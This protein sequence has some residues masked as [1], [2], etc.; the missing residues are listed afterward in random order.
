MADLPE[1]KW[2]LLARPTL[3]TIRHV[4]RGP[5]DLCVKYVKLAEVFLGRLRNEMALNGVEIATRAVRLPDGTK[6][7]VLRDPSSDILYI[8][9]TETV[10]APYLEFP[11]FDFSFIPKEHY[12]SPVGDDGRAY[13]LG[14]ETLPLSEDNPN[15]KRPMW[16]FHYTGHPYWKGLPD[17]AEVYQSNKSILWGNQFHFDARGRTMVSW[18]HS[19]GGDLPIPIIRPGDYIATRGDSVFTLDLDGYL[20][21]VDLRDGPPVYTPIH[22][23]IRRQVL[24]P[25]GT[26][27]FT[28]PEFRFGHFTADYRFGELPAQLYR[29]NKKW[30]QYEDMIGLI[31]NVPYVAGYTQCKV[32]LEGE[33]TPTRVSDFIVFPID[34]FHSETAPITYMV[35]FSGQLDGYPSATFELGSIMAAALG[36]ENAFVDQEV[37]YPWRFNSTGTEAMWMASVGDRVVGESVRNVRLVWFVFSIDPRTTT[38]GVVEYEVLGYNVAATSSTVA[39]VHDPVGPSSGTEF[40]Y[41]ETQVPGDCAGD[42]WTLVDFNNVEWWFNRYTGT[43]GTTVDERTIADTST[44]VP[45]AYAYSAEDERIV[46]RMTEAYVDHEEWAVTVEDGIFERYEKTTQPTGS[47]FDQY[48]YKDISYEPGREWVEC[49]PIEQPGRLFCLGTSVLIRHSPGYRDVR[50]V[51]R[52]KVDGAISSSSEC[53]VVLT[54]DNGLSLNLVETAVEYTGASIEIYEDRNPISTMDNPAIAVVESYLASSYGPGCESSGLAGLIITYDFDRYERV[55][56]EHSKTRTDETTR[57]SVARVLTY[58]NLSK[59]LIEY[60]EYEIEY[61]NGMAY[62]DTEVDYTVQSILNTYSYQNTTVTPTI[63]TGTI[64]TS[65]PLDDTSDTALS[66][67]GN[68]SYE[69]TARSFVYDYLNEDRRQLYEATA[70]LGEASKS[71]DEAGFNVIVAAN[72]GNFSSSEDHLFYIGRLR[73]YLD[74]YSSFSGMVDIS[75][76]EVMQYLYSELHEKAYQMYFHDPVVLGE[77]FDAFDDQF[78]T[79]SGIETNAPE[80]DF[81]LENL[82]ATDDHRSL[83]PIALVRNLARVYG[84]PPTRIEKVRA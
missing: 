57:S 4:F 73:R 51:Y 21:A 3:P 1:P 40:S 81:L 25:N 34:L 17:G 35:N 56:A 83:Y 22:T 58:S 29:N 27:A 52:D 71:V 42:P 82:P 38:M 13:L 60:K 37:T 23:T 26:A 36:F 69:L 18:W 2:A 79:E 39:T 9:T 44:N 45:I 54:A 48:P 14:D 68:V 10:Y 43:V 7:R 24:L 84:N 78:V 5:H 61:S 15:P 53:L 11:Y 50:W 67:I 8:D 32:V 6:I 49:F 64:I 55:E 63:N 59:G 47:Y 20:T 12:E 33:E 31:G 30:D 65:T 41:S 76:V 80:R 70:Y 66:T 28:L 74:S 72:Y 62:D 16:G 75:N 19:P 46:A 77:F